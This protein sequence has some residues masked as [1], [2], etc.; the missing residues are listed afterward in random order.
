[1]P[2]AGFIDSHKSQMTI[3]SV[4]SF[5]EYWQSW[6]PYRG[7]KW[8]FRGVSD[9]NFPLL[10]KVGRN[11]NWLKA[12]K[13]LLDHFLREAVGLESEEFGNEWER[14][15]IAQH[16]GLAT[17]LLDWTEN[18]LVAAYFACCERYKTEGVVYCLSTTHRVSEDAPGPF[19]MNTVSRYRP[20]HIS[21]RIRAQ[22]GLFTVHPKPSEAL[23][24]KPRS[25]IHLAQIK[26]AASAKE[27]ILWDLTRVGINH[28]TLFPDLSGLAANIMWTFTEFDPRR[29]NPDARDT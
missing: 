17:R 8:V 4:S 14:L 13:R 15:A 27:Q 16:H 25:G 22:R 6:Q 21:Q 11:E 5:V 9:S 3:S 7:G 23:I 28:A 10:P 29:V 18:P 19:S 20:R 24:H 1:M 2:R 12:E 26:I